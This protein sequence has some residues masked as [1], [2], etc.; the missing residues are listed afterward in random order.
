MMI[1][2]I[3]F[4]LGN[5]IIKYDQNEIMDNFTNEKDERKFMMDKIFNAPEWDLLDLG[6]INRKG[7]IERITKREDAKYRELIKAFFE[8][9]YKMQTINESIVQIAKKL[10]EKGYNIYVLSNMATENFEYFENIDFF[11]LCNGIIISAKEH[12]KKPDEQIYRLILE[13]YNLIAEECLFIDDLE[14]NTIAAN[15]IGILSRNIIPNNTEDV[16][17]LLKEYN[18]EI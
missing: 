7:A 15:K 14:R 10:K 18:V 3:I 5:V 16:I 1:K 2:N 4:D 12:M 9:W 6:E 17:K 11:K 13:R 8:T